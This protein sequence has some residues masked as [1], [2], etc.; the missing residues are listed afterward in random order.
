MT[1][2]PEF[3]QNWREE[4]EMLLF[5]QKNIPDLTTS[6]IISVIDDSKRNLEEKY[7]VMEWIEGKHLQYLNPRHFKNENVNSISSNVN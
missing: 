5:I 6:R 1:D 2:D 4:I 7:V 3:L